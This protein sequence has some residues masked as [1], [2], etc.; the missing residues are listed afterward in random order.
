MAEKVRTAT[1]VRRY[2]W[3]VDRWTVTIAIAL[4]ALTVTLLALALFVH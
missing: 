2:P 1:I 4:S 3:G